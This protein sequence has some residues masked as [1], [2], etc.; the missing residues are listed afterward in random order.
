MRATEKQKMKQKT[1]TMSDEAIPIPTVKSNGY[2][3]QLTT[4]HTQIF[5]LGRRCLPKELIGGFR[6]VEIW[7]LTLGAYLVHYYYAFIHELE[8][9]RAGQS[10]GFG[11]LVADHQRRIEQNKMRTQLRAPSSFWRSLQLSLRAIIHACLTGC[12]IDRKPV[13]E[14]HNQFM[15]PNVKTRKHKILHV[16]ACHW[17]PSFFTLTRHLFDGSTANQGRLDNYQGGTVR[18]WVYE[19]DF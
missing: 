8:T 16:L 17:L 3:M 1:I 12:T 11:C 10:S 4:A 9:S 13:L 18:I 2:I 15:P 19:E 5:N 14:M 6:L 7:I